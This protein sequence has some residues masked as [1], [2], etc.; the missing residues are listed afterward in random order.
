MAR[1]VG[2]ILALVGCECTGSTAKTSPVPPPPGVS[3]SER[4]PPA[5]VPLTCPEGFGDCDG[6]R[7]TGCE[8]ALS[9]REHCGACGQRCPPT[10][11]CRAG[12]C[13]SGVIAVAAGGSHSCALQTDGQLL[14]WGLGGTGQLGPPLGPARLKPTPVNLGHP[15]AEVV[16]GRYFTCARTVDGSVHCFGDGGLLGSEQKAPSAQPHTVANLTDAIGLSAGANHGCALRQTGE[17]LC[18]GGNAGGQLGDGETTDFSLMPIQVVDVR[19]A[20]AVATGNAHTCALRADET[21]ACWGLNRYGQLGDATT[22]DRPRPVAVAGLGEVQQLDGGEFHTCAVAGAARQLHCWGRNQF[23]QLGTGS[24][25]DAREPQKVALSGVAQVSAGERHTCAVLQDGS[26]H[27]FGDNDT[28]QLG[29]GDRQARD[30]PT[31]VAGF[32]DALAVSAGD[33]HTC[34]LSRSG[35]VACFGLD[36][37][38]LGDGTPRDRATPVVAIAGSRTE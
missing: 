12:A 21:V 7:A 25:Q 30:R 10:S 26:I 17:L 27:C 38:Q 9:A 13:F 8:Q 2:C 19:D 31:R 4:R 18:W 24:R 32:S 11:A 34:V 22:E 23:G 1:V 37:G 15:V 35:E 3:G 28:G 36:D 33:A 5:P 16:T 6:E 14:C 29:L 20:R